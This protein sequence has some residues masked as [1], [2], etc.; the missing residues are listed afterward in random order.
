MKSHA[1]RID[2]DYYGNPPRAR[3]KFLISPIAQNHL[4]GDFLSVPKISVYKIT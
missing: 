4:E 1:W 2:F 3:I